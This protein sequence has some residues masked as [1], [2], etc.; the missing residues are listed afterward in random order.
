MP[1]RRARGAFSLRRTNQ[2]GAFQRQMAAGEQLDLFSASS[3]P[4]QRNLPGGAPGRVIACDTLDDDSLLA[5][6]PGAGMRETVAL[7]AEAGRRRLPAAL[8]VLEALC[9]RFAGFGA[10]QVV[11]EQ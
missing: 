2:C 11:P 9:R 1:L 5:A 10:D 6:I 4:A 3:G 7:V 8:P